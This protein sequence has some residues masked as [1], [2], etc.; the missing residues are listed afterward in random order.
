MVDNERIL[1]VGEVLEVLATCRTQLV[2]ERGEHCVKNLPI[3]DEW[4][5]GRTSATLLLKDPECWKHLLEDEETRNSVY[6]YLTTL[7]PQ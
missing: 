4:G 1:S 2:A 6:L 5:N 7:T 3:S